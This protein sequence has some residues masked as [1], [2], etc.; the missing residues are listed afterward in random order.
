VWGVCV[1][2]TD[3]EKKTDRE[4]DEDDHCVADCEG[5]GAIIVL[6][7]GASGSRM[8]MHRCHASVEMKARKALLLS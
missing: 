1:N 5:N 3:E 2:G 7:R 4:A 6:R 8:P